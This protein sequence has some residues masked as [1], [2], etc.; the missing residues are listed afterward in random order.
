M[1]WNALGEMLFLLV[2]AVSVAAVLERFRVSSIVGY[3]LGGMLVGPGV[4]G[5]VGSSADVA[6][7]DVMTELGVSLLLFTIGLE[8]TPAKLKLFGARGGLLGAAQVISTVSIVMTM[9]LVMRTPQLSTAFAV[10]CMVTLSSTAVVMRILADRTELDAPHGRDAMSILLVQ[11]LAV[12]PMLIII[13]LLGNP[14]DTAEQG[15]KMQSSGTVAMLVGIV[16]LLIF[17]VYIL[18]RILGSNVF[19]RNRDFPVILALATALAAAWVSHAI[20]LSAE[21]GAF[22]AGIILA[23]TD[24]ARQMRA[25]VAVLKSVFLTLFFA[26]VG[27]LADVEWILRDWHWIQVIVLCFVGISIKAMIIAAII[28]FSGGRIRTAVRTAM[29]IAQIG[30]FSFVVGGVALS[31]GLLSENGFQMLVSATLLSLLA[32][33]F[34]IRISEDAGAFVERTLQRFGMQIAPFSRQEK[35]A[36]FNGHVVVAGFGPAGQEAANTVRVA[37]LEVVVVDLNPSLVSKARTEGIHAEIGNSAQREILEH[38]DLGSACAMI[39]TVPDPASVIGTVEQARVIAPDLLIVAR[40]R[41]KRITEA[42]ERAGAD[43]VL[44]E[45]EVI[46]TVLGSTVAAAHA[47][48]STIA[49]EGTGAGEHALDDHS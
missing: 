21:L 40:S 27:L 28:I 25:D 33:P 42:I 17:A 26:S 6:R 9:F 15:T 22:V 35:E 5:L 20:G 14:T 43:H 12:V 34:L 2:S 1:S 38:L 36:R 31:R 18:P 11:D 13:E 48:E 45:E 10:G 7:F 39:V 29:V 41:Y 8:I 16:A 19:R 49:E 23:R 44:A 30:E 4:L 46:G 37:G 24:F 32:T 3:L 47:P